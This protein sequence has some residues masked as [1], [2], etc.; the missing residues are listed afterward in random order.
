MNSKQDASLRV[1]IESCTITNSVLCVRPYFCVRL[2]SRVSPCG[3]VS[4]EVGTVVRIHKLGG[5]GD[6]LPL[7]GGG[8]TCRRFTAFYKTLI[9]F[10]ATPSGINLQSLSLSLCPSPGRTPVCF[11]LFQAVWQDSYVKSGRG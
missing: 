3:H 9:F 4:G 5:T 6:V 10:Q 11:S 1:E 7:S 8:A 2:C